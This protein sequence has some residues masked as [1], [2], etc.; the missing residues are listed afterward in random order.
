MK[1]FK[2]PLTLAFSFKATRNLSGRW[3]EITLS[4][5]FPRGISLD[6]SV[7]DLTIKVKKQDIKLKLLEE[8]LNHIER[9]LESMEGPI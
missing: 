4:R 2:I 6:K 7:H 9:R 1:S 5:F 3:E 8:K